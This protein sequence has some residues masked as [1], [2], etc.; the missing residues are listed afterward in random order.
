MVVNIN[1]LT[2]LMQKLKTSNTSNDVLASAIELGES[3][4]PDMLQIEN[5]LKDLVAM[6]TNKKDG[7]ERESGLL[8]IAGIA[9]IGKQVLPYMLPLLPML[10]DAFAD[11]GAPVREA[12]DLAVTNILTL[13][14]AISV[15]VVFPY[16]FEAM[17][18]K[19]YSTTNKGNTRLDLSNTFRG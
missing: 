5:V 13:I 11:K 12:A 10:I 15:K 14:D 2:A 17:T 16:L 19:W 6:S 9:L 1:D 18:K 7:M 3:I 8:G 4:K